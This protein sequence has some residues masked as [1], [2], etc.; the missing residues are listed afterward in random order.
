M[1]MNKKADEIAFDILADTVAKDIAL[2][3]KTTIDRNSK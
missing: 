1:S 3:L 2:V